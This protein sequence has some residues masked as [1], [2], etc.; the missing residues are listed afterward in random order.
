MCLGYGTEVSDGY[1][2]SL[3]FWE[4]G[5]ALACKLFQVLPTV[6]VPVRVTSMGHTEIVNHL[7]G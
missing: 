7:K 4:C 3:E 5:I 2:P 6:V 1:A